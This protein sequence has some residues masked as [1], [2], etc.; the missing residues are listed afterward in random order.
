MDIEWAKDGPGSDIYIVQARP[1]TDTVGFNDKTFVD[2]S[3][4]RPSLIISARRTAAHRSSNPITA[5]Y[6][7][8]TSLGLC[9][10]S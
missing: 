4:T 7:I 10:T 1:E 2:T 6:R 9:V 3:M 5:A 8:R